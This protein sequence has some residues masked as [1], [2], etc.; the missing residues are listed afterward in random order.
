MKE[1]RLLS[2][3][4]ANL[5]LLQSFGR[6]AQMTL[7]L[8]QP[9]IPYLLHRILDHAVYSLL[10]CHVYRIALIAPLPAPPSCK[11]PPPSY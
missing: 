6:K 3:Q 1:L 2:P 7:L 5:L 10:S 9:R 8:Y 4:R 11:T